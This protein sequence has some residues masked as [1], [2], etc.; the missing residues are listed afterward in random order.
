[1]KKQD[2]VIAFKAFFKGLKNNLDGI[3]YQI[4]KEYKTTNDL[5]YMKRGFHMCEKP[6]DCFRF[7]RPVETEVELALVKGYGKMYGFDAGYRAYDDTIGY[8]YITEKMEILKVFTR[9]EIINMAVD[10]PPIRLDVFLY[11]YPITEEEAN[12]LKKH[13]KYEDLGHFWGK[14]EKNVSE[15]IDHHQKIHVK[16]KENING[17]DNN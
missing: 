11:L 9:E 1:M 7:L 5:Q 10:M 2:E 6:E 12:Y 14:P 15:L 8:I 3:D 16:R 13:Y 17:Q 4:G